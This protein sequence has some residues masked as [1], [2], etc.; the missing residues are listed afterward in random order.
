MAEALRLKAEVDSV[1]AAVSIEGSPVAGC[2]I[3][4]F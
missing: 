1:R 4:G 2:S 3:G